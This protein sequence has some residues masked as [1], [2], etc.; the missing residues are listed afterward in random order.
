MR[1]IKIS[2][3]IVGAG[4]ALVLLAV[5]ALVWWVNPNDY[6]PQIE[7]AAREQGVELTLAGDIGWAFWPRVGFSIQDMA[8]A[9]PAGKD[10]QP[11]QV[12]QLTLAL[13]LPALVSSQIKV[14]HLALNDAR[15][16]L[17]ASHSDA[18][19]VSLL[20]KHAT[21]SGA[22]LD[23]APFPLDAS[24]QLTQ[25]ALAADVSIATALVVE[26]A[27][28]RYALQAATVQATLTGV[29]LPPALHTVNLVLEQAQYDGAVGSVTVSGLTLGAGPVQLQAQISGAGLLTAAPVLQLAPMALR[30]ADATLNGKVAYKAGAA[31][32]LTLDLQ[33]DNL[34]VDALQAALQGMTA[35]DA[36][37]S[38]GATSTA[39]AT[40]APDKA[41]TPVE[42]DADAPLALAG[43]V[44]LPG[45]YR[46]QVGQLVA[47][48]LR[49]Q[50]VQ[51]Q[52]QVANRRLTLQNLS[53]NGYDGQVT[54]NGSLLVPV[55]GQPELALN[56]QV[57]G[58]QLPPFLQDLHQQASKVA[59]GRFQLDARIQ[60]RPV[61]RQQ[62]LATLN[63]T[64]RFGVDGLVLDELNIEQRVCEAAAKVDGKS[65]SNKPWPAKTEFREAGGDARI[66]NGV[67][68]LSPVRA[69]LD[70][71]DLQGEGQVRLTQQTLDL[72]L[73]LTLVDDKA[74]ANFCEV[75]NP[76][77]TEL[78]WPLRCEGNYATQTGKELCGIDKSRLDKLLGQVAQKKLEQKVDEKQ[79]EK[80]GDGA[81]KVKEGLR[82]LFGR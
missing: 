52:A 47:N 26:A 38:A 70:T 45:D 14:S 23:G 16:M 5:L 8:A 35:D 67:V 28:K 19:P 27:A 55:T 29:D 3:M 44:S 13:D 53:A 41:K 63:G 7:R 57:A 18:A 33:A 54:F 39:P 82:S 49:W 60:A 51:L 21:V 79:K 40:P 31:P 56:T 12:G 76:R 75:M 73:D 80:F 69:R 37:T 48:H 81:D 32:W 58:L 6:K 30:L 15:L 17:P 1:A 25:G 46:L 77:L 78:T 50:D 9:V 2:V 10:K 74:A 24:M 68:N 42:A 34:N 20:V 4:V 72:P 66:V 22:N 71:L 65:V 43:A 36:A 62:L 59:A 11:I 64:A 61:S